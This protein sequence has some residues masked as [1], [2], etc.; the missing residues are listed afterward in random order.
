MCTLSRRWRFSKGL[1]PWAS[2]ECEYS[3]VD[4]TKCAFSISDRVRCGSS[5]G[6]IYLDILEV[7]KAAV[8]VN[9]RTYSGGTSLLGKFS[10]TVW[11]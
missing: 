11:W 4:G 9:T 1:R 5:T 7:L 10:L 2:G 6:Q 8:L 3:L